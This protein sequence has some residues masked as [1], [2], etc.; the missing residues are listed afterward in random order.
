MECEDPSHKHFPLDTLAFVTPWNKGGY[1][2]A[3]AYASKVNYLC[4]TWFF[5]EIHPRSEKGLINIGGRDVYD[6]KF[7]QRMR[8]S[9]PYLK[10]VPRLKFEIPP[11]VFLKETSEERRREMLVRR[12][13]A[14]IVM[15]HIDGLTLDIGELLANR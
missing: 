2:V 9:D 3:E 8:D 11:T 1:E 15:K 10:G 12:V 13:L 4:P 7:L 14:R 6:H 5:V